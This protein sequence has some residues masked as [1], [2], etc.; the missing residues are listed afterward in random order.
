MGF[1]KKLIRVQNKKG[2]GCMIWIC[3]SGIVI[4]LAIGGYVI[5]FL[6]IAI[7]LAK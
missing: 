1:E 2:S 3:A 5:A 7:E 6:P 4:A